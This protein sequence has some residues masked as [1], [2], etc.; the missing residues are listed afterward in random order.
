[1]FRCLSSNTSAFDR[2]SW[3]E[4]A[5]IQRLSRGAF[6]FTLKY[7]IR[8]SVSSLSTFDLNQRSVSSGLPYSAAPGTCSAY[9]PKQPCEQGLS[10]LRPR[11]LTSPV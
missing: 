10:A 5:E 4:R 9:E 11:A 3:T 6:L 7:P 1:M 8:L 2:W